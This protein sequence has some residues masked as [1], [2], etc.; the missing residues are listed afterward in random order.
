MTN[1]T[2]VLASAFSLAAGLATADTLPMSW[3][4]PSG[5]TPGPIE[6]TRAVLETSAAGASMM[7]ETKGMTPGHAFTVWWVAVQSP[8]NCDSRP[9][10]PMDAMGRADLMNS[11]ASNAGGGIVND[12]GTVRFASYL[13][14]GDVP[15]NFYP[16]TFDQPLTAEFHLVIQDHGPLIPEMAAEMLGG[17]RGGCTDESVPPFYP[18]TAMN[19][20]TP[21]PNDCNT[22]QVALF[23]Q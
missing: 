20:G 4:P 15:G 12:D 9:C 18:A 5:M 11:V 10:S 22:A 21:G 8:E 3:V 13:P 1:L 17:F 23:I 6:G 19:D 16:S 2:Y 7:I 14:V